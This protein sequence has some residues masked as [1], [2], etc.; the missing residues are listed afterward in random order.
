[1]KRLAVLAVVTFA[2]G[3]AD[4]PAPTGG[5][6]L[7]PRSGTCPR[8]WAVV[9]SDYAS[10][11]IAVLS[12]DGTVLSG[13]IL[14]SAAVANGTSAALSGDVVL[15]REPAAD[16]QADAL[17]AIDRYPNAVVTRVSLASGA[18]TAQRSVAT[19][20]ASNP[21]DLVTTADGR[22]FVARYGTNPKP[23][24]E[25]LDDGN[26]LLV[27]DA[28]SLAIQGR[29]DLS[30]AGGTY[31]ARADRLLRFGDL[32][33]VLL[34]RISVSFG[35]AA[36]GR[37]AAVDVTTATVPWTVDL[38]GLANCGAFASSQDGTKVAVSCSGVFAAGPTQTDR[39]DVVVLDA[40]KRPFSVTSRLAIAKPLGAPLAP[41]VAYDEDR[42]VGI[43]YGD[44]GSG[45]GDVV[46]T[47]SGGAPVIV[48][49]A[50]KAFVLGDVVCSACSKTCLVSDAARG[51]VRRFRWSGA[52]YEELAETKIEGAA[53]LPPR[54]FGAL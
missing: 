34:G 38:T 18:V 37:L 14:S 42:L 4:P 54:T 43:A 8:A 23:G 28:K 45:R 24:R 31:P 40:T 52:A 29:V 26:D 17:F 12:Q 22:A 53:G 1:M 46:W 49:T 32:V 41:A 44:E 47:S 19:G 2:C 16:G 51:T 27:V 25:P 11:S 36:D 30:A 21:H 20:F 6:A 10:S 50:A 7:P 13:A 48:A 39:S 5:V 15:P 35:D 9:S 33:L 3:V